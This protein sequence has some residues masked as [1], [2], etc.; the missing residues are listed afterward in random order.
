M[1]TKIHSYIFFF[2]GSIFFRLRFLATF[3]NPSRVGTRQNE[4]SHDRRRWN[5]LKRGWRWVCGFFRLLL[6]EEGRNSVVLVGLAAEHAHTLSSIWFLPN[7][8]QTPSPRRKAVFLQIIPSPFICRQTGER[9]CLV[10]SD[11]KLK[12]S[13]VPQLPPISLL[14]LTLLYFCLTQ[15]T[16][17]EDPGHSNRGETVFSF[18]SLPFFLCLASTRHFCHHSERSDRKRG[19]DTPFSDHGD[20][21]IRPLW[22]SLKLSLSHTH[23][24]GVITGRNSQTVQKENWFWFKKRLFLNHKKPTQII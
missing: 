21:Q 4:G 14:S 1:I 15:K 2:I 9:C 24:T 10:P 5:G 17:G 11:W 13:P 8:H 22:S 23:H 7:E 12:S 16:S 20:V 3:T 6:R 19:A 18:L